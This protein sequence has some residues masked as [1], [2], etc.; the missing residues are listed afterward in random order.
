MPLFK[1]GLLVPATASIAAMEEFKPMN[2]ELINKW[3]ASG[4]MTSLYLKTP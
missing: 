4:L 1:L 3:A 2:Q